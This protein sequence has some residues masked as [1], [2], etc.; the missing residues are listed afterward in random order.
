MRQ[1]KFPTQTKRHDVYLF[2]SVNAFI[3]PCRTQHNTKKERKKRQS[4]IQYNIYLEY[5]HFSG[6]YIGKRL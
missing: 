2:L 6:Q 4:N 1:R 5:F 3:V